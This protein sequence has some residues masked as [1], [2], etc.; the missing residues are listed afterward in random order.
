M[1]E[2]TTTE[3]DLSAIHRHCRDN[4]DLVKRSQQCGCFYCRFIYP[5]KAVEDYVRKG[6]NGTKTTAIC[7]HCGIDS[8]LPDAIIPLTLEMLTAMQEWW[9]KRTVRLADL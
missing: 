7:P 5:A 2:T 1:S 6:R 9:F 8:V 4:K 3:A